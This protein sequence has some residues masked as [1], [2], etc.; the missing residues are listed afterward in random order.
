[1]ALYLTE[2]DVEALLAIGDALEAVEGSFLRQAEGRIENKPRYRLGLDGGSLA[3]MAASDHG[4]GVAGVKTYAAG[5]SGAS[6]VVCLFDAA[7]QE[8]LALIEADHLGRLRTGA[9]SGVAAKYLAKEGARTLGVLGC[10]W[11]AETQI[12]AIRAA[13]PTVERVAVYCRTAER[14]AEFARRMG[15]EPVDSPSLAAAADVVVTITTSKDPVLRGEWLSPG[16][17]VVAAGANHPS[18]RELDNAV[19]ER[20]AFVCCDSKEDAM[21]ESGDLIEPAAQGV[22]DWLEVHELADV[23]SGRVQGRQAPED[24]VVF[25]SNGIA[26]W[27]VAVGAA[28]VVR[29]RERG[30]GRDL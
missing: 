5:R 16:A 28:A 15:A 23:V 12:E 3:V 18:R 24:V 27:D 20:A 21:I 4:L 11:Q 7:S 6:F 26:A 17:L 8:T 19:L 29:A 10:G 13:V 9:A 1:M 30:L 2:E 25:K 14:R 22:L